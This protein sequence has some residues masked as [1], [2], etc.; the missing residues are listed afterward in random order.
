MTQAPE[1]HNPT[2][3]E[4]RRFRT[5][6]PYYARF[7]LN[8]PPALI[9]RVLEIVGLKPGDRAMDLGCGPGLLAIP[10]A[11]AGLKVTAVDP[12]PEMLAAAEASAREAADERFG[13]GGAL[14]L[15][16]TFRPLES[17]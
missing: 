1:T 9:A 11:R 8:Y 12:E 14:A 13:A 5:T 3:Y 17:V 2:T 16:N 10:F 4:P 6:V 15:M 7:R